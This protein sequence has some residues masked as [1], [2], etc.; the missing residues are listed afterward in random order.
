VQFAG[1]DTG[2]YPG[3]AAINRWAAQSPYSFVGF[4]FDAPCHTPATFKSW[5]GT[6]PV[7]KASGLG[8]I[9][10]YVGLQQDGCGKANL[11]RAKGLA[12]GLDAVAKFTAEGFPDNAVVFLDVENYNGPL[13]A[14]MEEYIGGWISSILDSGRI[15]SGI[16]CPASKANQIRIAAAKE[17]EAH[18]LPGGAPVFWIVK[19]AAGFNIATSKSTDSGVTFASAWQGRL[20]ISET[21]GGVTIKI[22]QNVA[23][24]RDPSRAT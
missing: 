17:F 8:L 9:I 5:S 11:S 6:F 18:G 10:V 23:D 22:D 14:A 3:D 2:S 12:H 13:S 4:Y 16:Y 1:F 19:V 24:T 7:I 21:Q 15:S 20:D